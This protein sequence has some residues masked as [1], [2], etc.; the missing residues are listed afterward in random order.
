G[1]SGAGAIASSKTLPNLRYLDLDLN[2][3]GGSAA[4]ELINTPKLPNLTALRLCP[5]RGLSTKELAKPSRGPTLRGLTLNDGGLGPRALAA[6]V[7][8]FA[9]HGLWFLELGGC[10]VSDAGIAALAKKAGFRHLAILALHEQGVTD[11][12]VAA[13][14]ACPALASLQYLDLDT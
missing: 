9:V 8:C 4:A 13:L 5:G 6:L 10:D 1:E 3:I 14:A 7:A 11:R 2:D 12:G